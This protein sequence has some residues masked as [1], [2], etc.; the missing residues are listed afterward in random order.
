MWTRIASPDNGSYGL[1]DVKGEVRRLMS[2]SS[3]TLADL[4][5]FETDE[6]IG[7]A[8][9]GPERKGEFLKLATLL[10]RNGMPKI[11]P[12]WGGR[13]VPAVK[14]FLDADNGLSTLAPTK[15]D[16]VE[17]TWTPGRSARKVRA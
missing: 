11:D 7:E 4:H 5:L 2:R 10:E 15:P 6:R 9:L 8:V 17:G 1:A 14:A 16:G 3:L 12:L 13:Y